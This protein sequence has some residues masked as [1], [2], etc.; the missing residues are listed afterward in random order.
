MLT[1]T[2]FLRTT[3]ALLGTCATACSALAEGSRGGAAGQEERMEEVRS[4]LYAMLAALAPRLLL[5]A[6]GGAYWGEARAREALV[7]PSAGVTL[8]LLLQVLLL[9]AL[10]LFA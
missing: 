9:P 5:G 4:A 10:M 6:G 3:A 1:Y 8:A 2:S 7:L